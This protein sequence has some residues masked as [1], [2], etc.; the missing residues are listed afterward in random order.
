[1]TC[2]NGFRTVPL[3]RTWFDTF[4]LTAAVDLDASSNLDALRVGDLWCHGGGDSLCGL[5]ESMFGKAERSG[6]TL[7]HSG[8]GSL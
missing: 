6:E 7:L 3:A 8:G 2:R 5:V 1:M 4:D